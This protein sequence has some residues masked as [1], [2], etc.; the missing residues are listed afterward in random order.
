MAAIAAG[1]QGRR[2]CVLE[3]MNRAGLKILAS[4]GGRCNLTRTIEPAEYQ[5][6]FGR[7]GRFTAPAIEA[8]GPKS[9]RNLMERLGV[10]TVA[11]DDGRVYPVSQRSTD[12][13][14][15]LRRRMGEL[16]VEIRLD[17]AVSGLW[18]EDDVLKGVGVATGDRIGAQRVVLACGGKSWP[19]LGGTGGGYELA[20]QAGMEIT[21]PLPALVPLVTAERWPARVAGVS[22]RNARVRI[23]LPGQDKSGC[24]GDVLLT[25]RGISGPAVLNISGR[26]SQLLRKGAVGLSIEVVAGMDAARWV[27]RLE[28]WRSTNGRRSVVRLLQEY[29]P[30]SLGEVFCEL[31]D[32]GGGTTIAQLPATGRDSLAKVLG[33]LKLT[34]TDTE[35]FESAFVTRGGVKLSG[36]DPKSLQSRSLAGLY[37]AGEML[38][39]DGPCGGFS[40]QWAFASGWLAG[41]SA[42]A[43][44]RGKH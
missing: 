38:D 18:I 24:V 31:A 34:V 17:C 16:G 39:L 25:H 6:A 2:V 9:L 11:E 29:L 12:V 8:M 10:P 15:A 3:Q 30:Q 28:S 20:R 37:I 14:N 33:G 40:L 5:A 19:K 13:Q 4:G 44:A 41:K 21:E 35:G 36:V 26:V 1:E 43:E 42:A 7:Q 23:D 27:E 22:L 32:A